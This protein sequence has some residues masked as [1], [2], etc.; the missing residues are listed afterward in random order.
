MIEQEDCIEKIFNGDFPYRIVKGNLIDGYSQPLMLV[1]LY[2]DEL[3][4]IWNAC[5]ALIIKDRGLKF[6]KEMLCEDTLRHGHWVYND[7]V[8]DKR[9]K[10]YYCSCCKYDSTIKHKYCPGCGAK[11]DG[12]QMKRK[13][14]DKAIGEIENG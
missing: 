7:R 14:D 4:K 10:W 9:E 6:V 1:E 8:F 12:M 5:L 11:M 13:Q 2:D 3:L